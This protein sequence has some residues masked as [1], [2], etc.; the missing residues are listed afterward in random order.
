MSRTTITSVQVEPLNI[1]FPEP[2]PIATGVMSAAQNVLITL[3][4]DDGTI[5]YGE[6]SPI[7]LITGE[8]QATALAAAGECARLL[9]GRDVAHWRALSKLIRSVFSGQKSV[10][11]GIEMAMLDALTR[12]LHVPLYVFFGGANSFV[13]TDISIAMVS[14]D[15][16]YELAQDA[17]AHGLSRIKIKIGGDVVEDVAR[18]EA[19]HRAAPDLGLTLDAN[20]GYTPGNALRCLLE[21]ERRGIIPLMME[22]PV[23]KDDFEGLRYVTQHTPIPV[24]ADES[25]TNSAEVMRLL[26]AGAVNVINI[27]L[28]KSG[29]VDSLTIA[30]ICHATKTPLMIG[31]MA[32]SRL[33]ASA[34]AHF[35]AGVG[36]F[37]YIDLDSPMH[38]LDDPFTGGYEQ[39]GGVYDLSGIENGMGVEKK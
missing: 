11:A 38:L 29:L 33:G 19:I 8:S 16:A 22:Q 24:A 39:R 21:L 2:F 23:H 10:C 5:G 30:A 28:Q 7:S 27:K 36:G 17:V 26:A 32:E 4:L 18:V 1:P 31:A 15:H 3:T 37:S 12:S 25:A 6:C 34:S 14:P 9:E 35:A 20:Q 13:E